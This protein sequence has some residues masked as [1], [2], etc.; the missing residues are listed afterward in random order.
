MSFIQRHVVT[1]TVDAAGD[2]IGYSPALNGKVSQIR[3]VKTDYA[4]GVD[5]TITAEATG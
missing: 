2:G 3:Y 5:F 4:N 1:V